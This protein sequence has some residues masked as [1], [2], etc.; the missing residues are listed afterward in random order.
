MFLVELLTQSWS[1]FDYFGSIFPSPLFEWLAFPFDEVLQFISPP[2]RVK[3]FFYF[4]YFGLISR[5]DDP[6]IGL[7]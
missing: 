1:S 3:Y 7:L 4:L 6:V 2:S 5:V